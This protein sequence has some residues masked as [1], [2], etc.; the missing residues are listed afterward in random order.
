MTIIGEGVVALTCGDAACTIVPRAG[1]AIAGFWWESDGARLDW[2]RPAS[3]A[4][5]AGGDGTGMA[6]L[7]LVPYGSR[8][9]K[10]RFVFCGR[11]VVEALPD[12][13]SRPCIHGNGWRR[14]WRVVEHG[15]D[16]LVLEDEHRP[17]AWPW[18]YRA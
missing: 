11:E 7:P 16:R 4:A 12:P 13:G 3:P 15:E 17:D 6:C 9:R 5:V 18:A 8:M 2:L 14:D 10:G 1:G